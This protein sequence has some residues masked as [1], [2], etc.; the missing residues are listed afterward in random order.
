MESETSGTGAADPGGFLPS[1]STG[2]QCL[3]EA[4]GDSAVSSSGVRPASCGPHG[5]GPRRNK[6]PSATTAPAN[7]TIPNAANGTNAKNATTACTLTSVLAW[8]TNTLRGAKFLAVK[9]KISD[10]KPDVLVLTETELPIGDI[11]KVPGYITLLPSVLESNV[12]RTVTLI[13]RSLHPQRLDSPVDIPVVVTQVGKAAVIGVYRQWCL[14]TSSGKIGGAPFESKQL[15]TLEELVRSISDR[16][17]TVY[18]TGDINLDPTRHGDPTYYRRELLARWLSLVEEIGITWSPTG[19]TYTSY[20]KFNGENHRSVL[21][22]FYSRSTSGVDVRVLQDALS[23]H[24]PVWAQIGSAPTRQPARQTR[25]DRNWNAINRPLLELSLL[26][27][28]WSDLM[29][30]TKPMEAVVLLDKALTAVITVAVPEKSYTT[31]NL[32]VRLKEDTRKCMRN[33][34]RAKAQGKECYK[35]L[36]NK[37]LSMVRRDH[38]QHNLERVRKGGQTAAWQIVNE[39]TGKAKGFDLTNSAL[40]AMMAKIASALDKG[41]K[42]G[43][44]CFDFS[45]A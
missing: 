22:H 33:R 35:R 19:P 29:A 9:S 4:P 3:G 13:K 41:L 39:V 36:R 25:R 11:P 30:A 24:D 37:C 6:D 12:V 16:F 23:D 28:D 5:A 14:L 8:N 15:D 31:P 1:S 44:S 42:V 38:V 43:L 40:A 21:D 17:P 20:G 34:D 26:Q 10:L 32:N 45:S 2:G 18:I 7:A 27:W